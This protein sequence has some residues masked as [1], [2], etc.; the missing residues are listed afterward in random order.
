MIDFVTQIL[1]LSLWPFAIGVA[2]FAGLV[3]G[4]VGFG[5][6]LVLISGLSL[7]MP[8]DV[9]LGALILPTVASNILQAF[10]QGIPAA[11]QS[12]SKFR[13]FLIVGGVFLLASS[14]LTPWVSAAALLG[15]VGVLVV[16]FCILQLSGRSI[17]VQKSPRRAEVTMGAIAGFIGGMTGVWGPPTVAL[18]TAMETEKREQMRIQ[19]VIYGLG[20]VALVVG[21]TLSG[22]FNLV[23]AL[24]SAIL[25]MPA[26]IG[27]WLGSR[28]Q[29]RIDQATFRKVTLIILLIAGLNLIRRAVAG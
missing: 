4:V 13:R 9:A 1:P 21:H 8:P 29:D 10:R 23:T 6:P 19:G 24:L 11:V 27:V 25:L 14:Q 2:V 17:P 16:A 15:G 20:A 3:K 18:L 26:V 28:I 22:I 7:V 5:M 12:I